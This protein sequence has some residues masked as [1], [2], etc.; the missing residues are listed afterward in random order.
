MPPILASAVTID[1]SLIVSLLAIAGAAWGIVSY[2]HK[3]IYLLEKQITNNHHELK[4][5][6]P[7]IGSVIAIVEHRLKC[8]EEF[9]EETTH[10]KR[11]EPK[12]SQQTG[13]TWLR[14]FIDKNG[15]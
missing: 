7:R 15:H 13:G 11:C 9:Q 3:T 8:L 6:E 10:F 12:R 4:L 14:E 1:P 2:I 5:L